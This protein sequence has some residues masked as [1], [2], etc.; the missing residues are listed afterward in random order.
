M[1]GSMDEALVLGITGTLFVSILSG[2]LIHFVLVYRRRQRF[3][4]I[5]Q[6]KQEA[7]YQKALVETQMEIREET[8]Q[9]VANELHDNIGQMVS[10]VKMSLFGLSGAAEKE[11]ELKLKETTDLLGKLYKEVKSLSK[12]LNG[13]DVINNGLDNA[14]NSL[15]QQLNQT[16]RL[17]SSLLQEGE[18]NIGLD[19]QMILFR[20]CQEVVSN[21]IQ[22]AKANNLTIKLLFKDNETQI[23][24]IDDGC[25][26]DQNQPF[27]KSIG[28]NGLFNL[29]ERAALIN[30][31]VNIDSRPENGTS[32][33]ITRARVIE[34]ID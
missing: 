22:H 11:R 6:E 28:G 8:L 17:N 13:R 26:F 18:V 29:R 12:N 34:D 16:G 30:A 5:Q 31:E 25:G 14:L 23:A 10:V 3:F 32:V 7:V 20:M 19:E 2:F 4:E 27:K 15:V 33:I 21:V 1:D 9:F 24:I